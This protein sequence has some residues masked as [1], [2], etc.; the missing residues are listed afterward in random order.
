M[1]TVIVSLVPTA[2]YIQNLDWNKGNSFL[3]KTFYGLNLTN[4]TGFILG[5]IKDGDS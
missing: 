5:I 4:N 3:S 2:K 1:Y